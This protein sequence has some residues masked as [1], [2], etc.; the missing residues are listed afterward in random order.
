MRHPATRVQKRLLTPTER[1]QI[2]AE[3]RECE[4][5]LHSPDLIDLAGDRGV[6]AA[7]PS[8]SAAH[9]RVASRRLAV[10]KHRLEEGSVENLS[11]KAVEMREKE[12]KVLEE[13]VGSRLAPRSFYFA[14]KHESGDYSKTV[15]HLV[16][17]ENSAE[18]KAEVAR[19][20]NLLRARSAAGSRT[21]GATEDPNCGSIEYLRK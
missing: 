3:I 2:Q 21:A 14:K 4:M 18:H 16:E 12:I 11:K 20:K 6:W 10:L 13:R 19:L 9:S 1:R 15:K 5:Q 17:V 7:N 8:V